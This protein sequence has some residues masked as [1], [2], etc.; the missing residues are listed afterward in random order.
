MFLYNKIFRCQTDINNNNIKSKHQEKLQPL[1]SSVTPIK[2]ITLQ[3][4][5]DKPKLKNVSNFEVACKSSLNSNEK[6]ESAQNNKMNICVNQSGLHDSF[7]FNEEHI[8]TASKYDANCSYEEQL[9]AAE[10]GNLLTN[11][12]PPETTASDQ[13]MRR[14]RRIKF[15]KAQAPKVKFCEKKI[16]V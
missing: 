12:L 4:A 13:G 1:S 16:V 5:T 7:L 8:T 10:K 11:Q 3:N 6:G 14:S 15:K 9:M 2:K